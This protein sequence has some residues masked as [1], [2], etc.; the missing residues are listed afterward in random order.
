[1]FIS[2]LVPY[3]YIISLCVVVD[4]KVFEVTNSPMV[5]GLP[6]RRP[7]S[8]MRPTSRAE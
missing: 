8:M 5:A 7:S 6:L 1:M 3:Y 2:S 4:A